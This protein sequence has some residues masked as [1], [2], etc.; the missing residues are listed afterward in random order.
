MHYKISTKTSIKLKLY[1]NQPVIRDRYIQILQTHLCKNYIEI[2]S[3]VIKT[4]HSFSLG[5]PQV[6]YYL[7]YF[8][9]N[10]YKKYSLVNYRIKINVLNYKVKEITPLSSGN[11]Q[12][13]F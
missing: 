12:I 13:M 7:Y 6:N 1:F 9:K 11:E 3:F 10:Y 4:I 8:N 2:P 5:I